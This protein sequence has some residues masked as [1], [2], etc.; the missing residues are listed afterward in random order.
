MSTATSSATHAVSVSDL[1]H[2]FAGGDFELVVPR[3]EIAD[4]EHVALVGPSGCGKSTLLNLVAGILAPSCGKITTLGRDLAALTEGARR[5]ARVR[6]IGLVFQEFELLE[7]LPV[8]ENILLPFYVNSA[9]RLDA[10]A[11]RHAD[12]L[13]ERAGIARHAAKKPRQLSQGER[14]RVAVCRALVASPRLVLADEPTGNLDA[15]NARR[16][17]AL[18]RDESRLRGATLIIVT[19]DRSLLDASIRL[20]ELDALAAAGAR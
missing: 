3:L 12:E 11:A 4:G 15:A 17:I 1:A 2:R 13:L 18:L 10:A 16:V 20:V 8:R 9:L 7:H 5:A 19:H 14:Q 6:E